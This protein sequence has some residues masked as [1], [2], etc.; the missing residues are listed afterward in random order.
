MTD[1]AAHDPLERTA[2]H[3]G[4]EA[5]TWA[6][7]LGRNWF[8]VAAVQA[9]INRLVSGRADVDLYGWLVEY[10]AGR[11]LS[12]PFG[13]VLTLGCGAGDLERGLHGL[14]F[15]R[16]YEGIDVAAAAI[17]R[18]RAAAAELPDADIHYTV[19][20]IN[21]LA[22]PEAAYDVIFCP[23]SAHHFAALEAVFGAVR[24]AL[25]PGGVFVLNEYIGPRQFQWPAHQVG[26]VDLLLRH[27]PERWVRMGDGGLRRG[28]TA[29]TVAEVEAVDPTEAIRSDEILPVLAREFAVTV[30]AGYGG[31]LLHGLLDHV[32]V[33]F[34][35]GGAESAAMLDTFCA[36]EDWALA[37]GFL[38][39]DFAV[40][41]AER[42]E[43][44]GPPGLRPVHPKP[45]LERQQEEI[46]ALRAQVAALEAST[47]WRLTAPLRRL[48]R[49]LMR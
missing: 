19:A 37:H 20:D 24:R 32:G 39:H 38:G 35:D 47:S 48:R 41:V 10:L 12:L 46:A 30:C 28:F 23:M 33:N 5:G 36:L 18:A 1:P 29:P 11:G 14:G 43:D 42:P 17:E 7:G 8:E 44:A 31:S 34:V 40:I 15:A 45:L 13:R 4:E 16:R 2:A 22:L 6:V 25:K 9:R 21:T 3:W 26:L 49:I 27:L